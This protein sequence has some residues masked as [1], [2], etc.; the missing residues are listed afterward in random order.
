M[1]AYIFDN[2]LQFIFTSQNNSFVIFVLV[3]IYKSHCFPA[4]LIEHYCSF[5]KIY[6]IIWIY[7]FWITAFIILKRRRVLTVFL[8]RYYNGQA[9][10]DFRPTPK[11]FSDHTSADSGNF[12]LV[13][14]FNFLFLTFV[15]C[16]PEKFKFIQV[17]I[18]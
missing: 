13:F 5:I 10:F 4:W 11:K 17:S 16:F 15:S 18:D 1:H 7:K 14:T 3:L 2:F 8:P 6:Y 12:C 9:P